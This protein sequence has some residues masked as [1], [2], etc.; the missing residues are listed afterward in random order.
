MNLNKKFYDLTRNRTRDISACSI[1]PQPTTLPRAASISE[2]GPCLRCFLCSAVNHKRLFI[3]EGDGPGQMTVP[4]KIKLES[5]TVLRERAR[6]TLDEQS[7]PPLNS[8][9][10]AIDLSPPHIRAPS[11]LPSQPPTQSQNSC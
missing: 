1:V 7:P 3:R 4:L 11:P 9:Q 5:L 2:R 8:L 10:A 6:P